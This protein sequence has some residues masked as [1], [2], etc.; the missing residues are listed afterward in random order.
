MNTDCKPVRA[1]GKAPVRATKKMPVRATRE[2]PVRAS[3]KM[4]DHAR[5]RGGACI[6][7]PG[8]EREREIAPV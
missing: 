2:M 3:V 4:P 6:A 1:T 5:L 8:R 7:T